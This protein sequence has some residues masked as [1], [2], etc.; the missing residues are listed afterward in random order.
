[1]AW[2]LTVALWCAAADRL[3]AGVA[4]LR[5]QRQKQAVLVVKY[6]MA[7]RKQLGYYAL[8]PPPAVAF[9]RDPTAEE[10]AKAIGGVNDAIDAATKEELKRAAKDDLDRENKTRSKAARLN[11]VEHELG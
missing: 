2:D 9:S 6:L 10:L 8:A 3:S 4:L 7:S 1:M 11:Q 5:E